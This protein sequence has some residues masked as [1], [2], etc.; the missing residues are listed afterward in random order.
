[1]GD[2]DSLVP[3]HLRRRFGAKFHEGPDGPPG[4]AEGE[5]LQGVSQGEKEEEDG[6]F[7]PM[8]QNGRSRGGHDHEEVHLQPRPPQGS[9]GLPGGFP[10]ARE[11]GQAIE[12]K[13]EGGP[14]PTGLR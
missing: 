3:I 4:S 8:T 2:L 14:A 12:G 11:V 6:A 5:G 13:G 1:M 7:G 10:A 9:E